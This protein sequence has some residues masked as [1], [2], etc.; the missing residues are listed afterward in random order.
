M[1]GIPSPPFA[2]HL[3]AIFL[4][5]LSCFL[6]HTNW[7]TVFCNSLTRLSGGFGNNI[8]RWIILDRINDFRTATLP[9]GV[10]CLFNHTLYKARISKNFSLKLSTSHSFKSL[11]NHIP[12][13]LNLGGFHSNF[14]CGMYLMLLLVFDPNHITIV[15]F[16]ID[17]QS[18]FISKI[19]EDP[20]RFFECFTLSILK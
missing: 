20:N 5:I 17:L 12:S 10:I 2:M 18:R 19:I 1:F 8:H 11:V 16:N 7:N 3:T 9:S 14:R 6:V 15:F 13:I 4:L